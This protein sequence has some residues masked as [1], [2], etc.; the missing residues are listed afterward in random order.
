MGRENERW[1]WRSVS[2]TRFIQT[3]FFLPSGPWVSCL[4]HRSDEIFLPTHV[5]GSHLDFTHTHTHTHTRQIPVFLLEWQLSKCKVKTLNPHFYLLCSRIYSCQP[6]SDMFSETQI[7]WTQHLKGSETFW[8]IWPS[9]P[10]QFA[11]ENSSVMGGIRAEAL[12]LS[13]CR[14]CEIAEWLLL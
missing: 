6:G 5:P 12:S 4:R 1:K 14:Q 8:Q 9:H 2:I 3:P 11:P 7:S 13:C 10:H